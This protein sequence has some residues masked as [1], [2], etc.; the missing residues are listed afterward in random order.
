MFFRANNISDAVEAALVRKK[1]KAAQ[2]QAKARAHAKKMNAVDVAL[3]TTLVESRSSLD[4]EIA[5]FGKSKLSLRTFLQDQYKS[6]TLIRNSIYKSIPETSEFRM[7]QKPFK[8][9]MNPHPTPGQTLTAE[10]QITY[11]KRLLYVMIDEDRL[12]PMEQTVGGENT[13]LV[14][15]LPVISEAYLNPESVRLK[16]LQEATVAALA[17]PTDNPWYAQLV[18]EY[19]GKILYDQKAFYRVFAIQY[20]PNTGKN[21]FP[22]WEATTEPVQKDEHGQFVVSERD[23]VVTSDGTKKLLKSAEVIPNPIPNPYPNRSPNPIPYPNPNTNIDCN[24]NLNR[25]PRSVSP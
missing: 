11:L 3:Q 9:R 24:S 14:R 21:V 7:K 13:Q 22:C 6:R 15:R 16:K 5:T 12:R 2:M 4:G 23:L 10:M 25:H 17:Q 19:M 18:Q 8:L 20:V 1:R